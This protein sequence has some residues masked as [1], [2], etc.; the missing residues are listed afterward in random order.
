MNFRS[1]T[2]SR[3]FLSAIFMTLIV[4]FFVGCKV[5]NN[6]IDAVLA[7]GQP[8][9]FKSRDISQLVVAYIPIGTEKQEAITLLRHHGFDIKEEKRDIPGC[10]TCDP[11]VVSGSYLEKRMVPFLPDK[12][13]ISIL[14]GCKGG[15]VAH[16]AASHSPNPF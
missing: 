14:L 3:G 15:K 5:D 2:I 10:P 7:Q 16:V 8:D 1:V 4:F 6:L 11:L 13:S 9:K 12:S